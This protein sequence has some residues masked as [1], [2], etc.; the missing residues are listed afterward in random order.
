MCELWRVLLLRGYVSVVFSEL[1][2]DVE[3]SELVGVVDVKM[4]N[5]V[6]WAASY[7]KTFNE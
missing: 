5:F 1:C 7:G 4:R 6:G 2:R 3:W